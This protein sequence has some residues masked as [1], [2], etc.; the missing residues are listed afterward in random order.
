MDWE[1]LD[2]TEASLRVF[3]V[4]S[5]S[6]SLLRSSTKTSSKGSCVSARAPFGLL[7]FERGVPTEPVEE[8][9]LL[10]CDAIDGQDLSSLSQ[11]VSSPRDGRPFALARGFLGEAA[12]PMGFETVNFFV[13]MSLRLLGFVGETERPRTAVGRRVASSSDDESCALIESKDL[14]GP[15]IVHVDVLG[16]G[17]NHPRS[18]VKLFYQIAGEDKEYQRTRES[19]TLATIPPVVR[20]FSMLF[21]F[22]KI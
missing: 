14:H 16:P 4:S 8:K 2:F 22:T 13:G 21:D 12:V 18:C 20:E 10:H 9:R 1:A 17:R 5:S 6:A 3:S 7:A 11:L 19:L 15:P